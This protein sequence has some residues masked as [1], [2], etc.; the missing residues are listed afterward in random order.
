MQLS[1]EENQPALDAPAASKEST[2]AKDPTSNKHFST[3]LKY[4][5]KW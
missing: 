4:S 2:K 5:K 3:N 1:S